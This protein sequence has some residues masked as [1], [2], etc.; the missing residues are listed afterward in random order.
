MI[1]RVAMKLWDSILHQEG[2][3]ETR[4]TSCSWRWNRFFM[5][6]VRQNLKDKFINKS[7]NS[8]QLSK[9]MI[10]SFPDFLIKTNR[11]KTWNWWIELSQSYNSDLFSKIV[12]IF[13]ISWTLNVTLLQLNQSQQRLSRVQCL[14]QHILTDK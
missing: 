7:K 3:W 11:M 14:K 10:L 4:I 5:F 1:L 9:N 12:K 6:K 8:V 2:K 13:Y